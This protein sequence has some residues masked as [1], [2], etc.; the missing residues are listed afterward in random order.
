MVTSIVR[1][2]ADL[3]N[4]LDVVRRRDRPLDERQVVRPATMP[5]RGLRE[6]GDVDRAGDGQQLVFAVEQAQLAAVARRELP[7]GERRVLR[8]SSA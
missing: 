3:V 6:V 8:A 5:L 2:G 4:A 7:H 1:L